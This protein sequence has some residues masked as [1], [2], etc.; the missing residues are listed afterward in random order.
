[1]LG[2]SPVFIGQTGGAES[3]DV[4]R[5][6]YASL[7][8]S[9]V[10]LLL[11]VN[12]N[13][14]PSPFIQLHKDFERSN[15]YIKNFFSQKLVDGWPEDIDSH[16]AGG[17]CQ[18]PTAQKLVEKSCSKVTPKD[19]LVLHSDVLL[20]LWEKYDVKGWCEKGAHKYGRLNEKSLCEKQTN[21]ERLNS[22]PNGEINGRR[23][24]LAVLVHVK[25]IHGM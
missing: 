14:V 6:Y 18:F 21:R 19:L 12:G 10:S 20:L 2:N 25:E 3:M 23:N 5:Q 17:K 9:S 7:D 8:R 13:F 15:S 1:M 22:E 16:Y 4:L 11:L 24:Y